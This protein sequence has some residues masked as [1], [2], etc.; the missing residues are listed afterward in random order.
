MS[1]LN[2]RG[3]VICKEDF[4]ENV[5]NDIKKELMVKPYTPEG[6]G[7]EP[8]PYPI[9]LESKSKLYLPKYYGLQRFGVPEINKIPEGEDIDIKFHGT[10]RDEQ[11]EPIEAIIQACNDPSKMGGLLCLQCGAGKTVCSIN[12]ITQLGKKALIIVHKDFLLQQWKER[13][14]EFV[15]SA[16][17]GLIKAKIIDTEDKDIVLAS[18]QSLAMKDYDSEIFDDMGTLVIDECHRSAAQVFSQALKKVNFKYSIGLTATPKRADGLTKVFVWH[19]GDIVYKSKKKSDTVQVNFYKYYNCDPKYSKEHLLYTQKPNMA[20]MIN[21]ICEYEPRIEFLVDKIVDIL[22]KE[23][24]RRILVL[25][26]RRNH[27]HLITESLEKKNITDTGYYYGGLKETQLK[28]SEKKKIILATIQMTKEGLDIK[29]LDTLILAS[30]KTDIV[31]MVGRI[32]RVKEGERDNIPLII[33]IVDYF[34]IFVNQS[35]KRY[36]YYKKC[37]YEIIDNDSLFAK[38]IKIPKNKCLL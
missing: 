8:E 30:P 13:L 18:L 15:P 4:S 32:L 37:N 10:I 16:R 25:S 33:D 38:P 12:I 1:Y 5:I 29:G 34:S 3:Y 35:K 36:A 21:N 20:K 22:Q 14:N 31:Q 23:P 9:Y 24:N 27:L 2:N 11:K 28:E 19:I 26:D 7:V 17:I 6:Y